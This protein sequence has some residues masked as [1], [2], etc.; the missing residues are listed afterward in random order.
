MLRS[1][2][3]PTAKAGHDVRL[4]QTGVKHFHHPVVGD[5]HRDYEAM[6]LPAQPGLTLIAFTA[7]AGSPDEDAI[8]LLSL[9]AA[10]HAPVQGVGTASRRN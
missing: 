1:R 9:W 6:E 2:R 3:G 7:S 8:R 5:L 10:T 4:H